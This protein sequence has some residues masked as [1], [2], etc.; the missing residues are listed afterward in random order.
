MFFTDQ[1]NNSISI[2]SKPKKII[3]LVPSQT[4]LLF[5]LGLDREVVGITD[6]CIHP[7]SWKENKILVGGTKKLNI[8][9]V[10]K[11]QPDLIIGN[12]EENSKEQILE[13]S[14]H[15]PVWMSDIVTLEDAL[16]MIDAIGQITETESRAISIQNKIR[17][18]F[19]FF[20]T[21]ATN[22]ST[23]GMTVIYL[24]WRKPYL[25]VSSNT[26]IDHMLQICNL[27]NALSDNNRYP[28]V[29]EQQIQ[30]SNPALI[31]LSSEP[32]PFKEKHIAE[33]QTICPQ[34]KIVLV[35]GEMFS[36]YGSRLIC[37]PAY[38]ERLLQNL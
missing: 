37:A 38:F 10:H 30:K 15:F 22:L 31:F 8:E 3:S 19:S 6:Y 33:L 24:I 14:K 13:L 5:E 27:R 12:K 29:S 7:K 28:E 20:K 9:L 11:I 21:E 18:Q 36:W 26:F 32:Y 16:S 35:D 17:E 1:L 34:A 25:A 4:E 2:F 23:K